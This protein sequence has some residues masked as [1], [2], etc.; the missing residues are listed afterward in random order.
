MGLILHLTQKK[1]WNRKILWNM[2]LG[3]WTAEIVIWTA[4]YL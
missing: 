1:Y 2:I 3:P 4:A